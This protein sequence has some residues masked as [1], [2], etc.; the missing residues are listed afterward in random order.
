MSLTDHFLDAFISTCND[1]L[2]IAGDRVYLYRIFRLK[3]FT[4]FYEAMEPNPF[5]TDP[6]RYQGGVLID[7]AGRA[8]M[9]FGPIRG[10][11]GV[12]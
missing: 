12:A 10:H 4:Q 3:I 1:T 7:K 6:T 5:Q 11:A 8:V 2:H 9:I